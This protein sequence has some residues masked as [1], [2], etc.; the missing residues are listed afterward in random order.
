MIAALPN[1][2]TVL[3]LLVIP[4]FGILLYDESFLVAAIIYTAA[5]AT[6]T[7]DGEIA[8]R[9]D[10]VS[11]FGK[12]ADPAAD[13]LIAAT[14]FVV[15]T[16]MG[17]LHPAFAVVF[18]AKE[19]LMVVGAF[20]FFKQAKSLQMA[21]WF[22]KLAAISFFVAIVLTIFARYMG[23]DFGGGPF[24][25]TA[26]VAMFGAVAINVMAFALYVRHFIKAERRKAD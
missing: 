24:G 2:L 16:V 9:N 18:F 21:E 23:D 26:M 4:F 15:L 19:V 10:A 12:I 17:V 8:R 22:G 5:M 25:V 14:A 3:R 1:I 13:K 11:S 7:I 20:I 6:D